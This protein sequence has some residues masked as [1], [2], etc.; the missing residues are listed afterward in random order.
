MPVPARTRPVPNRFPAFTLIELLVVI[1]IIA[2]LLGIL[3][4][5]LASARAT[6]KQIVCAA[7]QRTIYAAIN[8]YAAD[9]KDMHHAKRLNYGA[10]FLR[11]NPSGP[12][13]SANLRMVRP[14]SPNFTSDGGPPDEAYW[15]NIYDPYL[16]IAVDPTWYTA[17]MPWVSDDA[18]PF[19]GWKQWRCPSAKLMDPYPDGTNFSP[20]H[21]YQTYGFNGVDDRLNPSTN[22]PPM[23]YWRRRFVPAYNRVVATPTRLT[24]IFQPSQIIIFQDAF[25]H[26]LDAN[27]DTL[28]DLD[29]YNPDVNDGD[30]RFRDWQKE[31]FRHGSGCNTMWGDGHLKAIGKVD[32]ND[33]LPWYTGIR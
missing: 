17:R 7:N 11:I 4:P 24:D 20:D 14:Y 8:A 21:Y 6:G 1:A 13:T 30:S 12:Y 27:G 16:D 26:M 19:A 31:Y 9:F 18:P 10:R 29:Q 32:Q 23:V 33:T 28:N 3:L 2:L 22:Q 25:E 5:S 15:G